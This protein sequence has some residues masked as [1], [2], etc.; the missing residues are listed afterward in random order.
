MSRPGQHTGPRAERGGGDPRL[1][2]RWSPALHAALRRPGVLVGAGLLGLL[3]LLAWLGPLAAPWDLTEHDHTSFL[4]PPS[5]RHWF[6]TDSTGRDLYVATLVGLRRSLVIG[7]LAAVLTTAV[8]V[9]VGTV[10]GYFPGR[11]DR[12]LTWL[13]DLAMVV[14]PLLVL[15]VLLPVAEKGGWIAFVLLLAAFGWMVT[16][17]MVRSATISLREH[18]YVRAARYMG[19]SPAAVIAR[20]ILPNL[21]SLVIADVTVNVSAAII[22]ETSLSYFGLGVQ[23]PDVSLGT[24]IADGTRHAVTHPW[25]FGFCT[26]LLVTLVLAVNLLGEGLRDALAPDSAAHRA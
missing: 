24:L 26:G 10:A 12:L 11:T 6:G 13:T 19:A 9:A 8:A 15:A 25:V 5:P 23:P 2:G 21:S 4:Q 1:P 3:A 16:A 7:L 22:A 17:R 18:E 20:H 14:P